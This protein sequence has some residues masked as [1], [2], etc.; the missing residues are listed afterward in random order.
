[1]EALRHR[2]RSTKMIIPSREILRHL[3]MF[4]LHKSRQ[5]S[6]FIPL[7]YLMIRSYRGLIE[8]ESNNGDKKSK[9]VIFLAS[10][11]LFISTSGAFGVG[12]VLVGA[13]K[14]YYC[15]S[16]IEYNATDH[17]HVHFT[18]QNNFHLRYR[19]YQIGFGKRTKVQFSWISQF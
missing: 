17:F 11:V 9:N 14:N 2:M 12:V 7:S 10:D 1:M 8:I 13:T 3:S 16:M 4:I 6:G 18:V 19:R 5:T 15:S